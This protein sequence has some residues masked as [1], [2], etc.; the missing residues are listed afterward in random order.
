MTKPTVFI[1]YS[2]KDGEFAHRLA[3][4]L[5]TAGYSVWVDISGLRGGQQWVREIDK[6]VR[7]C[8]AF[9]L[10]ISPDSMASEWVTRETL[11]AD[12][13]GKLV[14]PVMLRATGL[15][16]HLVNIQY[17]DF[18]GTYDAAV[19]ELCEALPPL[20]GAPTPAF[21]SAAPPPEPVPQPFEPEMILIPAGEFLMGSDPSVDS[22]A[23]DGEQPQHFLYLPDY[24][25]AK[26]PTTNAQYRAFVQ[27]TDH[28]HP[29]YWK[30]GKPPKDKGHH[31]VVHVSW[32]D[33]IAY[34]RWLAEVTGKPYCL[35][36][37]A[38][39]E[40]GVRGS[41]GRVYPW[42]NSWDRKRCNTEEGGQGDT[43]PV[44]AYPQGASL[45]GLLDVAGNVWEW[46]RSLWGEHSVK[47]S[48]HYPYD[49]ADGRENPYAAGRVWRVL[50]GGSWRNPQSN[51]R[52][53]SRRRSRP[54]FR[55]F[56]FGFRAAAS[57]RGQAWP[58]R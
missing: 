29:E 22:D 51:A 7:G 24:Y 38:E 14:V 25:L 19:Q 52:C 58:K 47:P 31:P 30:G 8:D 21:T 57:P 34:C 2:R 20:E 46:T 48:F 40:K 54:D 33:A 16:L 49:I 11:L 41:D 39:W 3:D 35:S 26:T 53:A 17:V 50:R 45:Y 56:I 44:G 55:N 18:R 13:L 5:R 36:S 27:A 28:H 15:P 4:D 43:T 1:S 32:H 23:R 37:E 42:G 12:S 10:I 6:A 9:V